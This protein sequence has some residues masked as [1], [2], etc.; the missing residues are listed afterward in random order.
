MK[1][2]AIL[3][4]VTCVTTTEQS[5]DVAHPNSF[6]SWQHVKSVIAT[7]KAE[8]FQFHANQQAVEGCRTGKFSAADES[9][10]SGFT[11]PQASQ[12]AP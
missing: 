11:L 9:T 3:L 7:E 5:P 2:F 12:S 1:S 6:Y 10:R 8:I 4:M